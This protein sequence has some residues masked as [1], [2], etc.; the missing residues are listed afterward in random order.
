MPGR[1]HVDDRDLMLR[2]AR[3]SR[4][5]FSELVDRYQ[6]RL[7]AFFVHQGRDR[8]LA[9][10]CTQEVFVRLYKSRHR[11]GPQAK[12]STFLFTIARNYWIDV[13]RAKRAR[14]VEG[15]LHD[16]EGD[17]GPDR[18]KQVKGEEPPPGEQLEKTEELD[19]LRS[20][21]EMLPEGQREAIVLGVI[22]GLP[23]AEV[24]E[25]LGIPIG[26]VK[27]RVHAAVNGL[28]KILTEEASGLAEETRRA[29]EG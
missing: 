13:I 19:R 21:L 4:T 5:A 12:F 29:Q 23:Y 24:S 1:Q 3:G 26:T 15:S 28:R 6:G 8:E 7:L 17:D 2:A 9:E 10:D 14:P 27:S 22:D 20:A 25:I 18:S 16:N 11:Y